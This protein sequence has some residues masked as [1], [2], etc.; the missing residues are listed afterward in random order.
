MALFRRKLPFEQAMTQTGYLVYIHA[1]RRQD[2]GEWVKL[3]AKNR[4]FLQPFEPLWPPKLTLEDF[5]RRRQYFEREMEQ[6]RSYN[7]MIR[8]LSDRVL[9]GGVNI[10]YLRRAAMQ[11]AS[12][13]YWLGQEYIKQGYMKESLS[14][15]ECFAFEIADIHRLEAYCLPCNYASISLL[16]SANYVDEGIAH[17]YLRINGD[18][19]DHLRYAKLNPLR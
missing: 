3:R 7:F 12:I 9:I 18:W 13:S 11:C 17:K 5:E 10:S 14:L 4:D 15:L 16:K 1:W 6:D 2:A 8:R 19:Q